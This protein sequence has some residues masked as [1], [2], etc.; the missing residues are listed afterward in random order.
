M[1]V[2]FYLEKYITK[3]LKVIFVVRIFQTRLLNSLGDQGLIKRSGDKKQ[4]K[5]TRKCIEVMRELSNFL[6]GLGFF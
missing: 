1:E 2:N 5:L 4:I 6:N 3:P